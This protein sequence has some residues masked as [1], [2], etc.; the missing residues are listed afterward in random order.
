MTVD[1]RIATVDCPKCGHVQEQRQDC[2]KCGIVFSKYY[3][4]RSIGRPSLP[5]GQEA[6]VQ[7]P[8]GEHYAADMSE[9]RPSPAEFQRLVTS[10]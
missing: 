6:G 2:R 10:V 3:V 1:E 5:E 9:P 7:P 4:L 8:V